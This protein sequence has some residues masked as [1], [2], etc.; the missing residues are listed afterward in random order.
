MSYLPG[1]GKSH[2]DVKLDGEAYFDVEHDESIPFTVSTDRLRITD[3]G[4]AFNV[5]NYSTDAQARL[6]L[7]QG[8]VEF[9]TEGDGQWTPMLPGEIAELDK[10]SG[11]ALVTGGNLENVLGWLSGSIRFE[12]ESLKMIARRLERCYAVSI[13]IERQEAEEI[14]FTGT[15]D[16]ANNGAADI[17][18][19]LSATGEIGFAR[20]CD[21][22]CTIK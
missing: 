3:L 9:S 12:D 17:L 7:V 16:K 4:T 2:R 1:F 21:S 5:C 20:I 6:A 11:N 15:F 14:R 10:D 8:K 22:Q 18:E 13:T 19:A